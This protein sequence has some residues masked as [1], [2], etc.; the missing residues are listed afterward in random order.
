MSLWGFIKRWFTIQEPKEDWS[1]EFY[2]PPT[3]VDRR[4]E[5]I[6]SLATEKGWTEIDYQ[7]RNKM[8]SFRKDGTRLNVYYTT[9]TVGTCLNHPKKGKTQLFRKNVSE[10]LLTKIM[11]NPRVHTQQGY[12]K[13]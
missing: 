13:K 2:I 10:E 9:M 11:D 6:R 5:R 4:V 3:R 12:Q 8:I 1:G 7:E